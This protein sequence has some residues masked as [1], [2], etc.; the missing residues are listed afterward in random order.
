MSVEVGFKGG[1]QRARV[2]VSSV[3]SLIGAILQQSTPAVCRVA[4]QWMWTRDGK[5]QMEESLR[6]AFEEEGQMDGGGGI[7]KISIEWAEDWEEREKEE[8]EGEKWQDR[9]LS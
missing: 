1:S 7:H 8:R 3:K 2:P 5:M 9:S 6:H 4:V